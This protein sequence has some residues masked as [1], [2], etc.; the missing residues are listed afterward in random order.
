MR[1]ISARVP[2]ELETELE[3]Y[4]EDENIDRSTAVRKLL[5]ESLEDWRRR[6][7]L[8]WPVPRGQI[9]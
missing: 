4:L 8:R 1:T 5:S 3:T 2:D 7:D 9:P 6:L